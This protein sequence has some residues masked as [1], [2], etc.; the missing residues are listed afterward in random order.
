MEQLREAVERHVITVERGDQGED[1]YA[2]RHELVQE[3][4][5]GELLPGERNGS[6]QRM[7]RASRAIRRSHSTSRPQPRSRATGP[8]RARRER[9]SCIVWPPAGAQGGA[10]L[11]E[12]KAQYARAD[13]LWDRAAEAVRAGH[14]R[15]DL[16]SR[17]AASAD[18]MQEG[19]DAIALARRAI[20]ASSSDP[21]RSGVLHE[22]LGRYALLAARSDIA[23]DAYRT[24][25][26]LVPSRSAV[27][28]RAR[29]VAGLAQYLQGGD[30][31]ASAELATEAIDIAQDLGASEVEANALITRCGCRLALGSIE[32]AEEDA[33]RA[34]LAAGIGSTA[35]LPDPCGTSPRSLPS[36]G[37]TTLAIATSMRAFDEA[38]RLGLAR[39]EGISALAALAAEMQERAGGAT[40]TPSCAEWS[41]SAS[42]ATT[43]T[44]STGYTPASRSGAAI[45]PPPSTT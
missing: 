38:E 41:A 9:P 22:R 28:E 43:P 45:S 15:I 17:A 27:L 6:T 24:A 21:V 20:A 32:A 35:E 29:V 3:A 10:C 44:P 13:E 16:L 2:F 8:M 1:R 39:S 31:T 37:S 7:P 30:N 4:V 42:A 26:R 40:P 25:V 12:A 11:L 5:E 23:D 14:D 19:D 18:A 36:P 33:R 34:E